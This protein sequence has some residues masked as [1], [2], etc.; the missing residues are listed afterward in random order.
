MKKR[1][2]IKIGTSTLTADTDMLSRGRIE[3]IARQ[4][5]ALKNDYE[6]VLVSSGAIAAAR[7][8]IKNANWNN[9]VQSKQALSAIGQPILVQT[10]NEVFRD[11]G[12]KTAQCLLTYQDFKKE[13]SRKNTYNTIAELIQHDY[14]PIIN[15]ND[16]VSVEEILVGD[17]DKLSAYVA[18]LIEADTLVLVSD[19]DGI[20]DKN[21]HLHQDARLINNISNL[22]DVR[23]FIEERVSELGTGGM[24][25]KI[26]AAEVCMDK[27]VE[28]LI[29]NG[30]KENYLIRALHGELPCSRF[31]PTNQ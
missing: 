30:V 23:P 20:F 4:I 16:T 28:M 17:N 26:Q 7:Q 29:V 19:I 8:Y 6:V 2:V 3:H 18:T 15:E 22:D 27:G 24:T 5:I 14:I 25:T 1:I 10:Y 21:P 9:L 12:L 31:I 11:F 13:N